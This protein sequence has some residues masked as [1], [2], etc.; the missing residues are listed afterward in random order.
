MTPTSGKSAVSRRRFLASAA[1]GAALARSGAVYAGQPFAQTRRSGRPNV[2]LVITDDQG[3][4]DM[5]CA[6]NPHIRTPNLDRFHARSVRLT[7][8]HVSPTCSPTR[9]A[10]LTGRYTNRTG[11]WHTIM[12]RS[13]LRRDETTL[14]DVFAAA[15]YRTAVFGKWHLGDSYPYRPQDRGFAEALVHGGGGVGQTPDWWG[16]TYFDDTYLRNGKPERF[17]GYCTD[18]WFAEAM[19][20]IEAEKDRPFFLYLATNAPHGPYRVPPEYIE[21]YRNRP[22][23]PDPAFYG[24]ISCIDENFGRLERKIDELGLADNTILIFMTDNGTSGRGFNA[25][26]RGRK[27]SEYE[28]GH[29]VPCFVRWRGGGID[30]GRDV[31]T[32]TA[33]IDMLPTLASLCGIPHRT[34]RPIDGMDVSPLL[35]G[36]PVAWPQ[37]VLVVDNQRVDVPVKGKNFAVMTDRWRLINGRELYDMDRDPGQEHNVAAEHPDVVTRLA[38]EYEKWWASVWADAQAPTPIVIG[39]DRENPARLTCHDWHSPAVPWDQ[40]MIRNGMR[41]NGWWDVEIEREGMY[42]FELRRW[43]AE[44]DKPIVAA[45]PGSKA[46][47]ARRARISIDGMERMAAV[48]ADQ[49]AAAFEMPLKPARCRLQTWF[50]DE[51]GNELCGAYYVYV[52]RL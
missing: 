19:R 20:F 3:Y 24:M 40:S 36:T 49:P 48:E 32:L 34:A 2:I 50:F 42:R 21:P 1:A 22:E 6:G 41:A 18:I 4:G 47:P 33:H 39:S 38:D 7:N 51:G 29:R 31:P 15:G 9:A 26:M 45:V 11:A 46:I 5:G 27:S 13:L 52:R 8:Y 16:N 25:G 17:R 12:G 35:R 43:P 10:L 30:G 37:R 23:V 44:L 28:G 14:A